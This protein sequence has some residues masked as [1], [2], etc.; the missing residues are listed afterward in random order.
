MLKTITKL[1]QEQHD[2]LV[3]DFIK[4]L[5]SRLKAKRDAVNLSQA[6]LGYC[7]GSDHSTISRYESGD[8]NMKVEMLPLYS[9][10]CKFKMCELFPEDESQAILDSFSS[11]IIIT[12]ERKK[13]REKIQQRKADRAAMLKQAG[14]EKVLKGQVYEVGGQEVFEPVP[15]AQKVKSLR[16]KYKDAEMHTEFRPYSDME[17][18]DFVKSQEIRLKDSVVSAG[19]FLEQISSLE[20][21]E[22]LKGLIADYIVDELVINQ[23]AQ[24][25][26]DEVSRRAYAYYQKLYLD[27]MNENSGQN[28]HDYEEDNPQWQEPTE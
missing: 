2:K 22:T 23:V 25:H 15:Q 19:R 14:Q 3:N 11:A 13:R 27:Y 4:T 8:R 24:E 6:E 12:V 7:F 20:N 10:Y 28:S 17:F 16:E 18:C 9:A 21:K 26:P 1:T 5:G